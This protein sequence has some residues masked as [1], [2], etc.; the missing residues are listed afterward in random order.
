VQQVT[1]AGIS[2]QWQS[3]DAAYNS[4]WLQLFS[5][6]IQYPPSNRHMF[7]ISVTLQGW[8]NTPC[9]AEGDT[10]G[11][12]VCR[13]VLRGGSRCCTTGSTSPY[14]EQYQPQRR[15]RRRLQGQA[16]QQQQQQQREVQEP[17]SRS[18]FTVAMGASVV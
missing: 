7:E 17:I 1:M 11:T 8:V 14:P 2:Y 12:A 4:A 15:L 16:G 9:P 10:Y 13:F 6:G 3:Q 18:A 5:V